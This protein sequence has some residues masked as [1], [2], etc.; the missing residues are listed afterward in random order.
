MMDPGTMPDT[1][2]ALLT[3]QRDAD[4]PAWFLAHTK[5]LLRSVDSGQTW[6][7]AYQTLELEAS[8]STA[9]L[10][11]SP[12]FARD[13]TLFA[14]ALGGILRSADG[15]LHWSVAML[16]S[17]PPYVV[18]LAT[19]PNY[20]E[21][22]LIFAGTLE[23][24]VFRSWDRGASWASWN[25]GLL[26]LNVYALLVSPNFA[27]DD[28]LYVGVESGIFRS[29]NGGRAWRET[30][31]PMEYG[32]VLSLAS[33]ARNGR[34]AALI[35]GTEAH[36]VYR[37]ED[38]GV[39]WSSLAFPESAGPVNHLLRTRLD[40]DSTTIAVTNDSVLGL[41]SNSGQWQT[42]YS[43]PSS[44]PGQISAAA[45]SGEGAEIHLVIGT[46]EGAVRIVE[47]PAKPR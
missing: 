28:T 35:A 6:H 27:S 45:V 3:C 1:V 23:D 37:S 29:T 12:D 15:G 47:L 2:N 19:S 39:T 44:E 34:P 43:L 30:S 42:L 4:P 10:A 13:G 9:A 41:P 38:S 11:I 22:G 5:G 18:A 20:V 21:D 33:A 46:T 40:D 31:F 36:G 32:P 14:G 25:F 7:D 8:L 16:P 26:D 24:G 17:P